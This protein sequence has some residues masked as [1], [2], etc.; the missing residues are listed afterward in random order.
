LRNKL[1]RPVKVQIEI[2]T[3]KSKRSN[4]FSVYV[5]YP[6]RGL[7]IVFHYAGSGMKRV[8]E[9]SYFAGRH[10]YPEVIRKPG[11]EILLRVNDDDW[12]FPNSGVTFIWDI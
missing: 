9:V 8:R 10:P 6:T 3:K 7:E 2:V 5:V 12:I 11:K 1:N 4:I